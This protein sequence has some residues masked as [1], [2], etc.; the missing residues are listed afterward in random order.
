MVTTGGSSNLWGQVWSRASPG[1][2]YD[3]AMRLKRAGQVSIWS[4]ADKYRDVLR[5][6]SF[7]LINVL[8]PWYEKSIKP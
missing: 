8:N 3:A 5:S 2:L 6:T 1:L 7:C 4:R